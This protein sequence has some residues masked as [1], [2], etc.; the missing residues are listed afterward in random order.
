MA[1][2]LGSESAPGRGTKP[3]MTNFSPYLFVSIFFFLP[4]SKWNELCLFLFSSSPCGS[5]LALSGPCPIPTCS[6]RGGVICQ[7]PLPCCSGDS[8]RL[9]PP[10]GCPALSSWSSA[11]SMVHVPDAFQVPMP[12]PAH[13]CSSA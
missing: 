8:P 13:V 5:P 4:W 7:R 12:S 3:S 10:P 2:T 11:V 1:A 9:S 6:V